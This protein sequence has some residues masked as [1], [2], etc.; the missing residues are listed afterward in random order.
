MFERGDWGPEP[1]GAFVVGT[2]DFKVSFTKP[3]GESISAV[4][5]APESPAEP[6][7]GGTY[8]AY[9]YEVSYVYEDESG[10]SSDYTTYMRIYAPTIISYDAAEVG[11]VLAVDGGTQP[12]RCIAR[13]HED[14]DQY[15]QMAILASGTSYGDCPFS[16]Y[17]K[18][19]L[20]YFR[21]GEPMFVV[22]FSQPG[23]YMGNL[24]KKIGH[25]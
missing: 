17:G 10:T 5:V 22:G 8:E 15:E 13:R 12:D 7:L 16:S 24:K 1:P 21:S 25:V 23:R 4:L 14:D 6:S 18:G 19:D 2:P 9:L 11:V 20:P 3:N